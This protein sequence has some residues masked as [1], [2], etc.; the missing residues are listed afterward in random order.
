MITLWSTVCCIVIFFR[1]NIVCLSV[2]NTATYK[3]CER[4]KTIL[5]VK[6][7]SHEH[8]PKNHPFSQKFMV[9]RLSQKSWVK[10]ANICSLFAS[11]IFFILLLQCHLFYFSYFYNIIQ[12]MCDNVII[13]SFE[14]AQ[15]EQCRQQD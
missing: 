3:L 10:F 9:L 11:T 7:E 12:Q 6:I 15:G 13:Y 1:S 4:L 8:P 14:N 5:T 2:S